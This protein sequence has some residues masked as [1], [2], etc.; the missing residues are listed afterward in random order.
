MRV[1]SVSFFAMDPFSFL[2]IL[3]KLSFEELK[4]LSAVVLNDYFD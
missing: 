4:N 1:V 2:A 3:S